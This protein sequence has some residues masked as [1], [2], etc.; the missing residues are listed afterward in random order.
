M[1]Q[2]IVFRLGDEEYALEISQIKEVVPTPGIAKVPLMPHYIEGVANIRGSVLAIV[3]LEKRFGLESANQGHNAKKPYTLVIE[4][5]DLSLGFLVREVPNT[6]SVPETNID[7]SSNLIY[8]NATEK[9]YIR[10]IVKH[11]ERLI[12]LLDIML[13]IAKND[14]Q[15]AIN[16]L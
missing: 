14:V 13:I 7:S 2:L 8:D 4:G 12:I 16:I 11:G 15:T 9:N 5:E 3:D 6:L 1:L 10:G